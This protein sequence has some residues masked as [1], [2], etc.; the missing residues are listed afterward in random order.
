MVY[1]IQE[2]AVTNTKDIGVRSETGEIWSVKG[3]DYWIQYGCNR[4]KKWHSDLEGE[5]P[6]RDREIYTFL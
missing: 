1:E 6:E 3:M 4:K 5:A 2:K